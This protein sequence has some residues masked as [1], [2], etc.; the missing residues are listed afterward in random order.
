MQLGLLQ[1]AE[2]GSRDTIDGNGMNSTRKKGNTESWYSIF[3]IFPEI[4]RSPSITFL[5]IP[6]LDKDAR[7]LRIIL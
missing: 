5:G 7:V 3:N 4:N 6:N 1:G 2:I